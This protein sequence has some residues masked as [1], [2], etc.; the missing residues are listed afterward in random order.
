ML[1]WYLGLLNLLQDSNIDGLSLILI[2]CGVRMNKKLTVFAFHDVLMSDGLHCCILDCNNNNN[3]NN[4][5]QGCGLGLDVS[6]RTN[7]SSRSRLRQNAQ[8]LGLMR[9]GSR[10]SLI[11]KGLVHI[12]D[13][14]QD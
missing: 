3:N 7:V 4:N 6:R 11:L 14:Q 2:L 5:T 13:T 10:L 1:I 9:L 8:S 12:P